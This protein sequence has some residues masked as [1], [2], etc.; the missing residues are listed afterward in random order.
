MLPV[1][2]AP[3]SGVFDELHIQAKIPYLAKTR[4]E[5]LC[6]LLLERT[7][8]KSEAGVLDRKVCQF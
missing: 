5:Y 4:V 1:S 7:I 3:T 8:R 2:S 6:L